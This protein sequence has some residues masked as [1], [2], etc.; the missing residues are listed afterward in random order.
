MSRIDV[1][2]PVDRD[3]RL[4]EAVETF[5]ALAETGSAPDLESFAAQYPDLGD[6]L[7]EALEGLSLLHGLVG[8]VPGHP[9]G[10]LE[11]GC[12]LAGYR[13][14]G[15]LGAGGMG[16]VY[17]A[18]HMDLDRPVAL[19]VL[20]AR[21]TRDGNGFRRFLN[22]AKTAAGLHHTHIVPV[23]D[24]GHVGGLCYYA[25]QRI[26]GCGLDRVVRSLRHDRTVGAARAA[27]GPRRRPSPMSLAWV[28]PRPGRAETASGRPRGRCQPPRRRRSYRP[29]GRSITAGSPRS[30]GR[31]RRH[32]PMRTRAMSSTGTSSRRTC[33][34]T[35]GGSSG[36][37]TSAWR[38]G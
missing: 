22:E 15:E 13:I 19:K 27:A 4:G 16:V 36:S 8:H 24:V 32:W 17:E 38:G 25:M 20:D 5:L 30:A 12:R 3:E 34:S 1:E 28:T 35:P 9:G 7:R 6:D 14:I 11:S 18:V 21:V 2:P 23:F 10:R 26:E 29:G 37:P 33:W 31:R